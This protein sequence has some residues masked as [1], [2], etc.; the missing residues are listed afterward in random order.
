MRLRFEPSYSDGAWGIGDWA[1]VKKMT[2][3]LAVS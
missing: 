2:R 3:K 1:L